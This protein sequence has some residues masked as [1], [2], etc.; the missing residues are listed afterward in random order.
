MPYVLELVNSLRSNVSKN[1]L[2]CV[3]EM[4]GDVRE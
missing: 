2:T 3:A 4:Y 1:A